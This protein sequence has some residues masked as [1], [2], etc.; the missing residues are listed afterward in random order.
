VEKTIPNTELIGERIKL[1]LHGMYFL[2]VRS[3]TLLSIKK[4]LVTQNL[5]LKQI[6]DSK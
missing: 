1:T 5:S 4:L 6:T 3:P 2:K